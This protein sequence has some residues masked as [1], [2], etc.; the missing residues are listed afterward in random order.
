M[1]QYTNASDAE[2]PPQ[3]RCNA[4]TQQR[5]APTMDS[6]TKCPTY[7]VDT[8]TL[9]LWISEYVHDYDNRERG[10]LTIYTAAG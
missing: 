2:P 6:L 5:R 7:R 9:T 4:P 1:Y 10:L 8:S 3:V